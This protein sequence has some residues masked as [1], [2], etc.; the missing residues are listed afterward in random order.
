MKP[1]PWKIE[2]LTGGWM[3]L[4]GGNIFG[5]VPKTVWGKLLPCDG[6]NR[7]RVPNRCLLA[8]RGKEVVLIDTGYGG[9]YPKLDR[10]AYAMEEGNPIFLAL[11]RLGVAPNDVRHLVMTHLHFD[12]AGGATLLDEKKRPVPAFPNA[13][14]YASEAEWRDAVD[15]I[16]ELAAAYPQNNLTPLVERKLTVAYRDGDEILPGLT[17][18]VSGGHTR[19][20]A[21]AELNGGDGPVFFFGDLAP[22]AWHAKQLWTTSYDTFILETRLQKPKFFAAALEQNA[23]VFWAHDPKTVASRVTERK[24]NNF[25]AVPILTENENHTETS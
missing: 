24:G 1:K 8:R 5:L 7:I 13:A 19:G 9:K 14:Y 20:H 22:T 17:M 4:D 11:D 23:A 10:L 12:H 6:Q 15:P 3:S 25:V 18:R 16:P 21:V 2:P